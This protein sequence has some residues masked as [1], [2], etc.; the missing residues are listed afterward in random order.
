MGAG[1]LIDI[2]HMGVVSASDAV[3]LSKT[4][5][6]PLMDSH[7]GLRAENELAR[8][9]RALLRAHARAIAANGG[10]IGLGTEG[11]DA[12]PV[13]QWLNWYKDAL[14]VMNWRGVALGTDINGF[15]PQIEKDTRP[16]HSRVTV[17]TRFGSRSS[18]ARP[19]ALGP[20]TLGVKAFNFTR[21]GIAHYG[22]LPDFLEAL[23]DREGSESAL[24]AMFGTAGDVVAMWE[25]VEATTPF[26][27]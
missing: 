6:Y 15:A 13:D 9:E 23:S 17:A 5:G 11:S 12:N 10:V 14:Q 8:D 7:T 20:Y 27:R 1:L 26:I 24:N 21:D 3:E 19:G 25:R 4:L 22:M 2:A 18:S 16:S